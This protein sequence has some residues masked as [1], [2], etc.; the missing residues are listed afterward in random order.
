MKN[1][2]TTSAKVTRI[3]QLRPS[4]FADEGRP[5]RA[6]VDFLTTEGRKVSEW[7]DEPVVQRLQVGALV[8]LINDGK[9]YSIADVMPPPAAADPHPFPA[10]TSPPP[11][12]TAATCERFK[13]PSKAERENMMKYIEFEGKL[14]RHCFE[15]AADNL[16]EINL[17]SEAIKDV[18]TTLFLSVIRKYNLQ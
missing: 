2:T 10:A 6:P 14:Y 7:F 13:T 9:G 1:M 8:T 16:Q 4:K 17:K 5:D 11:A 18:A 12:R 3:G 15:V